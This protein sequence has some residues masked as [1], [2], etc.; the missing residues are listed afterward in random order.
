MSN[1]SSLHDSKAKAEACGIASGNEYAVHEMRDPNKV[2][3]W[4]SARVAE[5][6]IAIETAWT[7]A[8]EAE[9]EHGETPLDCSVWDSVWPSRWRE[10]WEAETKAH[11]DE[12][13]ADT[14]TGVWVC[15]EQ[16]EPL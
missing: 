13:W 8:W 2:A 12:L 5:R 10:L 11:W 1:R 7:T 14:G 4:A 15:R 3:A 6:E 9:K 16:G